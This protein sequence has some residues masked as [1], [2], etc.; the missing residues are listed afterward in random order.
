MQITTGSFQSMDSHWQKGGVTHNPHRRNPC[1]KRQDR[2][3][4]GAYLESISNSK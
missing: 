4:Y 3:A 1:T 2:K